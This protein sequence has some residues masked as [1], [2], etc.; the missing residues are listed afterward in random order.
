MKNNQIKAMERLSIDSGMRT[1]IGNMWKHGYRTLNSCEGESSE[2][3]VMF[4]GGDGWFEENA[5][6]YGLTKVENKAC[7]QRE[8]LE[9][10]KKHNLDPSMFVDRRKTCGCGAG[11][12]GN[13]VY[14]GQLM[15]FSQ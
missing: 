2:A 14:R 15:Q 8:F 6:K 12:N 10:V 9:E 7:C 11:V 1:L 4:N 5:S 13:V 3:Y